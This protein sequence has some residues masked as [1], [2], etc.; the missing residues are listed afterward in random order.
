[1]DFPAARRKMNTYG[2]GARKI[3]VHDLFD[4]GA[5][6]SHDVKRSTT[7]LSAPTLPEQTIDTSSGGQTECAVGKAKESIS[8]DQTETSKTTSSSVNS[9]P[10]L[11]PKE[12]SKLSMFDIQS[13]EDETSR[14]KARP[15]SKK[16]KVIPNELKTKNGPR[17]GRFD[18]E[19][20]LQKALK[21]QPTMTKTSRHLGGSKEMQRAS[22]KTSSAMQATGST[23]SNKRTRRLKL[24]PEAPTE[25]EGTRM[26][27]RP[28][29][30]ARGK[31]SRPRIQRVSSGSSAQL[32]D[33]SIPSRLSRQSTPKRKRDVSDD[34]VV[35]SPSPS[36]LQMKSLRLTPEIHSPNFKISTSD[37]EMTEPKPPVQGPRRGRTRLIDRLDA[38]RAQSMD[39]ATAGPPLFSEEMSK[40]SLSQ[41]VSGTASPRNVHVDFSSGTSN[42]DNQPPGGPVV[43]PPPRQRATYARQRSHLSDMVDSLD[44]H[45][46]SQP[47]FSQQ[48]SFT[49]L[50]SH[51]ELDMEDG[52]E[53]EGFS[54]IKSIHELRRGG[55][56]RKFD[57]DLHTILEDI[58]SESKSLRIQGLL[59][60]ITKLKDLTFLRHFQDSGNF[61]R[62]TECVKEGTDGITATLI[63]L[64]FLDMISAGHSSPKALS[65]ILRALY[66]TPA[67]LI[68]ERR[69][70]SNLAKYRTQNI[71]KILVRDITGFEEQR[72]KDTKQSGLFVGLIVLR[73]IEGTLRNL[74]HLK[75]EFPRLPPLLLDEILSTF[76][77][78]PGDV[79]EDGR[80]ENHVERVQLLLS[81]L[82][83]ACANHQLAWDDL[84]TFRVPELGDSVAGVMLSARHDQPQIEHS[85]LRLIVSLSNNEPNICEALTDG[86]LITT[87]FQV[88]DDHFLRLAGLAARE[89]EFDHAQLESVILAVGCLLNLA[90]CADAAREKMLELV[91]GGKSLVDRLVAIFNS[92][93]DQTSEALTIDQTQIL[94]AFGY[95]SALL[96]TLCLNLRACQRISQSINGEG[97]SQLFEAADIFV[98]H[99]QT[100][101]TALG[102]DGGPSS[103]FTARFSAV[104][105]TIKLQV[106]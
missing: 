67:Q 42:A 103:G 54:Q 2:K 31:M 97:L 93:V 66:R 36:E 96:C 19:S 5:L 105:A 12:M 95:I 27:R 69:S 38:P 60:L 39:K 50:A 61:Q 55:A 74:I 56:I 25:R 20:T 34:G 88:I 62:L 52:D 87:V 80:R 77:E 15:P 99:L 17:P 85:C 29:R 35:N 14:I 92:H 6:P 101:E 4:A 106:A 43:G 18:V 82:E 16:R 30:S 73:S 90:E 53:A 63:A 102:D 98:D 49:S 44:S 7:D 84:S 33:D 45:S 40:P 10:P 72:S 83:I 104:L 100:V 75:E 70:L 91:P 8:N 26:L 79:V 41:P 89:Q 37:E 76:M 11:S 28:D 86:R 51:M 3:F 81:L 65:Q 78:T 23:K 68:S 32:S 94:V 9:S 58:E 48:G 1:M 21:G 47:T 59:Q 57:L 64:V 13:S 24:A 22:S 46:S 71:S